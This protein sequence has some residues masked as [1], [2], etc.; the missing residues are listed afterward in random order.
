M[1]NKP[2]DDFY[3]TQFRHVA[4]CI[5]EARVVACAWVAVLIYCTTFIWR[6]GY[7]APA[8]R[9]TVPE[10]ILGIPSWVVWGL[11]AP[12]LVMIVF[13]WW[14]AGF[15]MTDDEPYQEFPDDD[16]EPT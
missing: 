7:V 1:P 6:N 14:F 8:D 12:W 2:K 11:F 13:A 3:S 4:Q 16:E 15:L 5:R 10:L 9:P